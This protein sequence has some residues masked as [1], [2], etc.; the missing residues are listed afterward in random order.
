[1]AA[2]RCL[3]AVDRRPDLAVALRVVLAGVALRQGRWPAGGLAPVPG[4]MPSRQSM[5]GRCRAYSGSTWG[6]RRV[7]SGR[8]VVGPGSARGRFGFDPGSMRVRFEVDAEAR[9]T[10]PPLS[11][12]SSPPRSRPA[13]VRFAGGQ[14]DGFG[15]YYWTDGSRYEAFHPYSAPHASAFV[16]LPAGT[17]MLEAE[18][19]AVAFAAAF[20]ER[21]AERWESAGD[22][23]EI[24]EGRGAAPRCGVAADV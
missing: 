11:P 15:V 5:R 1:M 4:S 23:A 19:L 2:M 10:P 22:W 13:G 3:A 7:D 8:V 12:A 17:I 6:R 9:L 18:L 20:V 14:K 16:P 21:A 24:G